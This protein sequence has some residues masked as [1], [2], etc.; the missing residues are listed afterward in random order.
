M[1]DELGIDGRL[2]AGLPDEAF[3]TDGLLTKRVLRAFALAM[4]APRAGEL[5]WSLGAGTGSIAVDV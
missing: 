1:N 3:G 5:L 4:L 2:T